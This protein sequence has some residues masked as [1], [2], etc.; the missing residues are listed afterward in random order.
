MA[1][2]DLVVV[3]KSWFPPQV[4][5]K[6]STARVLKECTSLGFA[7]PAKTSLHEALKYFE[8]ELITSNKVKCSKTV[9]L[10]RKDI[11]VL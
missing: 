3:A 1:P 2:E 11:T 5:S 7:K 4:I 6:L 8:K 10:T 9:G